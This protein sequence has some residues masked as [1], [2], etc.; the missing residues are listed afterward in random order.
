MAH[1]LDDAD[2]VIVGIDEAEHRFAAQADAEAPVLAAAEDLVLPPCML[3]DDRFAPL[4]GREL[5]LVEPTDGA[6]LAADLLRLYRVFMELGMH[7]RHLVERP[8]DARLC[9]RVAHE[10]RS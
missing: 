7:A 4:A 3:V 10:D 6:I 5:E 8:G 2:A 1:P 9:V